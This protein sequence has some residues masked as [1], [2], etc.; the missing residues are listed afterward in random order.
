M[1]VSVNLTFV[2]IGR[3]KTITDFLDII[4]RHAFI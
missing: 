1:E 4:H 2:T 3:L